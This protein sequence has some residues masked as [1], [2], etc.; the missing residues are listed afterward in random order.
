LSEQGLFSGIADYSYNL[1]K[2]DIFH[3]G[4]DQQASIVSDYWLLKYNGLENN[5]IY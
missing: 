5:Q 3:Y 4:L 2:A 1:D